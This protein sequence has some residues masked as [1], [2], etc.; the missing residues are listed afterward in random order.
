[1]SIRWIGPVAALAVASL[2]GCG[3]GEQQTTTPRPRASG[4]PAAGAAAG[5]G[6]YTVAAVSGG[7]TVS[8]QVTLQGQPPAVEKIE[9]SKDAAVCGHEK[10]VETVQVGPNGGLASVV[11][12]ID[13]ISQGKD[14]GSI[15]GG[16]VDQKECHYSPYVQIVR[17]GGELAILNSDPILHNIHAYHNDKETLFN[18]AQPTQ[19]MKT[20]KK[21]E[22]TGP[23]HLKC[24]V[25]SWMSAW[26]FVAGHPYYA[27]TGPD[28][29]F[30]LPD[31]PAGTYKVKAWHSKYG[32]KTGDI[33]VSAGGTATLDFSMS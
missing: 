16:Q 14:W 20:P 23:V 17:A 7:G 29:A 6:G 25:H 10:S 4:A 8:G 11:V 9:V 22:K 26:V 24:D 32:E 2:A 27:V 3:G 33:T 15:S 18:L 13:G 19:G 21:L 28:G 31:V 30:S 5:S 1:M 12:W